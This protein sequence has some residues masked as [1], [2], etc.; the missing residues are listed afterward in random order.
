M[1]DQRT[2]RPSFRLCT[3]ITGYAALTALSGLL[4]IYTLLESY[5]ISL[6]YAF[7]SGLFF[8]TFLLEHAH[9]LPKS[10]RLPKDRFQWGRPQLEDF[11]A[12]VVPAYIT[13]FLSY[14]L[15]LG[16]VTA[17]ALIG[18]LGAVLLPKAAVPIF[19]GSFVGM[20]AVQVAAVPVNV[21]IAGIFAGL[22]FVLGKEVLNGFGGK[23]GTIAFGGCVLMAALRRQ[24]LLSIPI[25]RGY[26]AL[27]IV[28]F[29]IL[30][31][32]FTYT[33][34][35]RLKQGPVMASSVVGI[36]GGLILPAVF[37]ENGGVLAVVVFCA[38][39]AGM[40]SR[41]RL[42]NELAAA[43]AG[44]I[45][46]LIFVF[47][48]P[49]MGGAGGKLGT[50][51]FMASIASTGLYRLCILLLSRFSSVLKLQSRPCVKVLQSLKR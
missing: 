48:S 35:H 33:I 18:I 29:S 11:F 40:S 39:F 51:A 26:T 15:G 13:Y 38:S 7:L 16:A 31:A 1:P 12:V 42:K 17:S 36:A 49:H 5:R 45:A 28:M 20:I 22:L 23:L 25:P 9:E 46:G 32:V 8:L 2:F 6:P 30:G 34:S 50:I 4:F 37:P 43:I 14:D 41:E 10:L 24:P 27:L 21:W 47:S 44:F 19:S 3:R